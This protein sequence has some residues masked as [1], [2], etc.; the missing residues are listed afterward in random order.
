LRRVTRPLPVRLERTTIGAF[1]LATISLTAATSAPVRLRGYSSRI[2][3]R[4]TNSATLELVSSMR[5][6]L[7]GRGCRRA[8]MGGTRGCL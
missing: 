1:G 7:L 5:R 2:C 4:F 6:V 3:A 8:R